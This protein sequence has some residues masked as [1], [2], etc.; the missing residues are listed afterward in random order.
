MDTS[1]WHNVYITDKSGRKMWDTT[2]SPM[3]T[4]SE[5]RNLKRHL[6]AAIKNP[7]AYR[8]LDLDTA[9]IMLDGEPYGGPQV[10]T[11]DQLLTNLFA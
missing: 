3:S 10:M 11:D 2:A 8:F 6:E 9:V 1:G 7:E 5:I 4:A